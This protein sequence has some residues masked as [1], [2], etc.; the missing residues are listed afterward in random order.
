MDHLK[1]LAV[2]ADD[3][4]T[5]DPSKT[6]TAMLRYRREH[7]VAVVDSRNAGRDTGEVVGLG[8][9][10]P[11]LRDV[12]AALEYEPDALLLADEPV[13]SGL[14]PYWRDQVLVA[15]EAGLDVVSG[16][17]Y[18]LGEDAGIRT[19]A[20]RTGARIWDLRRSP[21]ERY[22]TRFAADGRPIV[23]YREHR[24]GSRTVLA[25]GTD[26]GSG[27]MTTMLELDHAAR[28][29]GVASV[30]VATGQ[31][32]MMVSGGGVA[33]DAVMSDFLNAIVEE[34]VHAAA[35]DHDLVLVEGQGAVN[36][37]RYSAVTL[38]LVHGS[39]P[40]AMILCHDLNRTALGLLPGQPLPS[41]SR[42]VEINEQAVRWTAPGS[43]CRVAGIS[44]MTAGVPDAEVRAALARLTAETGLPATDVLRYGADPLLDAVLNA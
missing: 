18:Q 34:E 33:V 26:C 30:F 21:V 16:L 9:G 36:H 25:V 41:L 24:R 43:G 35:E 44:V 28:E 11:I 37:P 17:H 38:G 40:D 32:G 3:E 22:H 12:R 31:V 7:V 23:E 15:V 1:R 8:T 29:R 13:G 42:A 19:A 6:L 39:R 14:Q 27:K 5:P 4:I 20:E 10:I 2:L